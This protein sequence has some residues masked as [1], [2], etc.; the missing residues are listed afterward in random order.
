M[1]KDNIVKNALILFMIT[2]VAGLLLGLTSEITAEAR[3]EQAD[4][5]ISTALEAV[6]NKGE[7]SPIALEADYDGY[8]A[9]AYSFT[10]SNQIVGYAFQLETTEGYGDLISMMIGMSTEGKITGIDIISHT[11]TP[12]LGAKADEDGFKGHFVDKKITTLTLVKGNSDDQNIDAIGGAT[13]T[14]NAVVVAVNDAIDYYNTYIKE[15]N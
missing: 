11:E 3:L 9:A 14:S 13:I 4:K 2:L 1:K 10:E 6:F 8:I 7:S 12:G 15:A 5:R